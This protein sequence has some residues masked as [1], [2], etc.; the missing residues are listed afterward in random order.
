[1]AAAV[2]YAVAGVVLFA[3]FVLLLR[4]ATNYCGKSV[5]CCERWIL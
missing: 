4:A 1:M 2:G 5:L 3:F